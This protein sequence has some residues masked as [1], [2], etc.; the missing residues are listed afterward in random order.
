MAGSTTGQSAAATYRL[1]FASGNH[2]DLDPRRPRVMGVV[3]VTPDSFSDGGRWLVPEAAVTHALGLVED[4]AD[5]LDLGA[6]SSRPGGGIY[7]SGAERVSAEEEWRRLEPVLEGLRGRTE[8]P[9]SVDTR[10][11]EI[12]RRALD[13][14]AALINDIGGLND[15]RMVAL[16]VERG[17]PVVVM[18]SRGEL[19]SMQAEVRYEDAVQEVADELEEMATHA[20]TAGVA[21]VIV[22]PGIG[23]GKSFAHNLELVA[24][25][26]RIASLGYPVL[27]G[28][29]RKGYLGE[30]TGREPQERVAAG[31]ATVGR[32]LG[33]VHIVRV[34]D[35]APTVDFLRVWAAHDAPDAAFS[36]SD[37][38][39][40][41]RRDFPD[42]GRA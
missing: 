13:L 28:T 11:P 27:L 17:C 16:I 23:F 39:A 30:L 7:G 29:S 25:L 3:N 31:L 19:A 22:D 41:S 36:R 20:V 6:E 38:E 12:A 40:I 33:A 32:A 1:K 24:G 18:H 35:V 26:H 21:Q 2:L 4:G 42:S 15:P 14:G 34:H 37:D 5:L 8:A 9:I 10:K